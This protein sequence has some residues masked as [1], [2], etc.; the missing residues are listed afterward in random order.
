MD[1][2]TVEVLVF[3]TK[4]GKRPEGQ[5][6]RILSRKA[7]E[8]VGKI[9]FST[10]YAFVVPDNRKV[11]LDIFIPLNKVKDANHRDK[12]I[13]KINKWPSHGQ[14]PEGEVTRTLGPAGKHE[15]EMHSI[16][17]E[18]GLPFEFPQKWRTRRIF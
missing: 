17:A 1:G 9:E 11:H 18:F 3:P 13:V 4:H 2:D 8:F 15:A 14:N 10:R 16:M 6:E 7:S 12:V 5:V